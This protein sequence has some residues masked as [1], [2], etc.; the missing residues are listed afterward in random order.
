MQ[1]LFKTVHVES[2][3]QVEAIASMFLSTLPLIIN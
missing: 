1:G 3:H 2:N